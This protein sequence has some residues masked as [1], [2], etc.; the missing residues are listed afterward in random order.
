[1]ENRKYKRVPFT[2]DVLIN[3]AVLVKGIDISKSGLYVHTGRSFPAGNIVDVTLP[4]NALKISVKAKVQHNQSGIGMGLKFVNLHE[5]QAEIINQFIESYDEKNHGKPAGKKQVLLIDENE[6]SRRMN[7]SKLVMDGFTVI[8]ATTGVEAINILKKESPDLIIMDVFM[9]KIDGFK[10]LAILKQSP[11][12]KDVP[13]IIFSSKGTQDVVE[14]A[15]NAGASEFLLKMMTTPV[16]LSD[17]VKA[18]L[19]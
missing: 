6:T 10:V 8:E 3:N 4:I 2:V 17:T 18:L 14:K 12:W 19:G 15:M 16:K 5:E 13:V 11:K 9:Q 1:M 7:K